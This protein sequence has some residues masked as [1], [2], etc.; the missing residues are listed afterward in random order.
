M[1]RAEVGLLR[2]RIGVTI[3]AVKRNRWH[4]PNCGERKHRDCNRIA[5][6]AIQQKQ[7]VCQRRHTQHASEPGSQKPSLRNC[8]TTAAVVASMMDWSRY[9]EKTTY[10]LWD[11][12][13]GT[14]SRQPESGTH[15]HK[16][17]CRYNAITPARFPLGANHGDEHKDHE[18][19]GASRASG[20]CPPASSRLRRMRAARQR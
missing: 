15:Q 11:G 19:P 12:D 16:T 6:T 10:F 18:Q 9:E 20:H 2:T 4:S 8:Q 17:L 7:G 1:T 13:P 3:N 5:R 14:A